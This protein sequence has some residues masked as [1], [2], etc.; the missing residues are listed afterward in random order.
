MSQAQLATSEVE[1]EIIAFAPTQFFQCLHCEFA[2]SSMQAPDWHAEQRESSLPPEMQAEYEA[3][4]S[5]VTETA[6]RYG[7]R[8]RF[9]LIDA[10]SML[11]LFKSIRHRARRFPVFVFNGGERLPGFDP[12]Q[13]DRA[14]SRHLDRGGDDPLTTND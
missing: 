9:K 14:L 13:L 4:G 7:S 8:V 10:A 2:W 11:G 5:W 1:V 12:I 3:I 6:Q